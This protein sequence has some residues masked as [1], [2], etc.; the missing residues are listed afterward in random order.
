MNTRTKQ[1]A[2]ESVEMRLFRIDNQL[3]RLTRHYKKQEQNFDATKIHWGH[4]GDLA[5][6]EELLTRI[7]DNIFKEG[8][9][10]PENAA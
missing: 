3:Q 1:T 8:E 4:D 7:T 10:A 2:A 5:H 9:H 6:I